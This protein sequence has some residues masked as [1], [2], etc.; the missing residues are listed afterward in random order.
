[1]RYFLMLAG[2]FIGMAVYL[3]GSDFY[4]VTN[5]KQP[6]RNVYSG[7]SG[8]GSYQIQTS[9]CLHRAMGEDATVK[10]DGSSGTIVWQD[11][12]TCSVK[13]MGRR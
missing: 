4:A 5:V 3:S 1:M 6:D 11:N 13:K 7:Q 8:G 10:W 2:A 9:H 12:S